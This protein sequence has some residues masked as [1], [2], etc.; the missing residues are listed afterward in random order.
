MRGR[1][2]ENKNNASDCNHKGITCF[3]FD[4]PAQIC[5]ELE[6]NLENSSEL[7]LT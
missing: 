2:R 6:M 7:L 4:L 3:L 1:Q 5:S